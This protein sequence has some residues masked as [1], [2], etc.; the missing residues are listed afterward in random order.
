MS[1]GVGVAC[2]VLLLHCCFLGTCIELPRF[3]CR[4]VLWRLVQLGQKSILYEYPKG[5]GSDVPMFIPADSGVSSKGLIDICISDGC[6]P[7]V[8]TNV[9]TLLISSPRGSGPAKSGT[10][11]VYDV[12][13]NSAAPLYMPAPSESEIMLMAKHCFPELL[14]Q[15]GAA[16]LLSRIRRWGPVPRLVLSSV[17]N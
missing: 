17:G 10:R 3:T 5:F 14:R 7:R 4:Y 11:P 8:G 2:R 1:R 16:E 13:Q 15:K 12:F 9:Q 6:E